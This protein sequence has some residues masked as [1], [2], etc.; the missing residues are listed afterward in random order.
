MSLNEGLETIETGAFNGVAFGKKELSDEITGGEL[1]IPGSVT[2]IGAGAFGGSEC[3]KTVKFENGSAPLGIESYRDPSRNAGAFKECKSL[4]QVILPDN[5]KILPRYVFGDCPALEE[6]RFGNGLQ[7][8]DEGA[9]RSCS[10]LQ[11]ASFPA[12]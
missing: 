12:S 3:L 8:I 2:N 6:V 10:S 7:S 1:T 9:F 11:A 5:L 4:K